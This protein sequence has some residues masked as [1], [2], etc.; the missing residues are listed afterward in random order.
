MNTATWSHDEAARRAPVLQAGH[1]G[2]AEMG[3][4]ALEDARG[5][6]LEEERAGAL[7]AHR[8]AHLAQAAREAVG[9]VDHQPHRHVLP[10]H[11]KA[12]GVDDHLGPVAEKRRPGKPEAVVVLGVADHRSER[13]SFTSRARARSM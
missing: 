5:V 13:N 9:V 3:V 7:A 8:Q 11:G 4:D 12:R 1:G 2:K 10:A 6:V